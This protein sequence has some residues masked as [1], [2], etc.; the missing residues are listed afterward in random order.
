MYQGGDRSASRDSVGYRDRDNDRRSRS[1]YARRFDTRDGDYRRPRK[2]TIARTM[3]HGD[4][5]V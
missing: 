3:N 2:G 1:P 5:I 4:G